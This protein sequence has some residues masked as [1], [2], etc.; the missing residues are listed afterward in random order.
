M[1]NG[2]SKYS[3]SPDSSIK[4]SNVSSHEENNLD[5]PGDVG[6]PP[7]CDGEEEGTELLAS[8][9]QDELSVN[10]TASEGNSGRP[11]QVCPSSQLEEGWGKTILESESAEPSSEVMSS[12]P[13]GTAEEAMAAT[14]SKLHSCQINDEESSC[15][16]TL[17]LQNTGGNSSSPTSPCVV[18]RTSFSLQSTTLEGEDCCSM[19][20]PIAPPDLSAPAEPPPILLTS[21]S[22]PLYFPGVGTGVGTS[23]GRS[24]LLVC[25]DSTLSSRYVCMY[26]WTSISTLGLSVFVSC[27][28]AYYMWMCVFWHHW[29]MLVL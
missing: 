23:V 13:N 3:P 14:T 19:K 22:E 12:S 11:S 29:G 1:S 24:S 7:P 8:G 2:S 26:V 10:H 16:S 18:Q 25:I 6:S 28:V 4:G 20:L 21:E 15:G 27:W 17:Q 9:V 5:E